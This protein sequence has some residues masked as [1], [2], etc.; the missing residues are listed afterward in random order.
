M[1][2]FIISG[3]ATS[4]WVIAGLTTFMKRRALLL[5]VAFILLGSVVSGYLYNLILSLA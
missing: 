3:S 1:L 2:A 5:Y 4:A